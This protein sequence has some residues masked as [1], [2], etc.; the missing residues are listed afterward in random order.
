MLYRFARRQGSEH[1][2]DAGDSEELGDQRT[3]Q[4]EGLE[5]HDVRRKLPC[6]AH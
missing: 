4:G 5:Q 3:S 6:V 2:S 1:V